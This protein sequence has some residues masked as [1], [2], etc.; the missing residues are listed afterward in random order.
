MQ[1][2]QSC[3]V[4]QHRRD[5]GQPE[6]G[7]HGAD[8]VGAHDVGAAQRRDGDVGATPGEATHVALDLGDV[9]EVTA[10]GTPPG[11]H[12]LGEHGR[13]ATGR[14]VDRGRGLHHQL[15]HALGPLA[16]RQQLHG[17]DDVE[18][19]HRP[20]AAGRPRS[21]DDAHVDDGVDVLLG[22]DLR[23]DRVADVGAHE[24]HLADVALGRHDVDADDARDPRVLGQV[25]RSLAPE[26]SGDPG[27][28]HHSAHVKPPSDGVENGSRK[29]RSLLAELATLDARLLEQLAVLLLRHALAP[30][31]DDR[32]HVKPLR[33]DRSGAWPRDRHSLARVPAGRESRVPRGTRDRSS[34]GAAEAQPALK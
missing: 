14:A 30:L 2:L 26:V 32:T 33:Y 4:A 19:F 28:Q 12:V 13:V 15:L 31:L 7:G 20:A 17:A 3:V 18:L 22:D 8:H 21:R 23:D 10:A 29:G 25:S 34:R 27:D 1:E 24:R 5:H 16:G 11:L 6:V 9:L